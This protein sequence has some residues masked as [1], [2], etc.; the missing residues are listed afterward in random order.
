M[1][2]GIASRLELDRCIVAPEVRDSQ[3]LVPPVAEY[4]PNMPVRPST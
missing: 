3:A 1:K 2:S 4:R